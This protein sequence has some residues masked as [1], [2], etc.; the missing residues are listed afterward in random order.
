MNLLYSMRCNLLRYLSG[1]AVCL[2]A[3]GS[4]GA[5]GT[6][7]LDRFCGGL[8]FPGDCSVLTVSIPVRDVEESRPR[9]IR[10]Y[11]D[12]PTTYRTGHDM[13]KNISNLFALYAR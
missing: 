8:R 1:R 7:S 5:P 4:R 3:M 9:D 13:F 2:S 10:R 11:P 12:I 6:V